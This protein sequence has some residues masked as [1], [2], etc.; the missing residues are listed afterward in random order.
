M[1]LSLLGY[2]CGLPLAQAF[3]AAAFPPS[4]FSAAPRANSCRGYGWDKH[5]HTLHAV[6]Q[7]GMKLVVHPNAWLVHLPHEH[8]AAQSL[9]KETGQVRSTGPKW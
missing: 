8:S 1:A 3:P 2:S 6:R 9:S 5:V 4:N 7:L